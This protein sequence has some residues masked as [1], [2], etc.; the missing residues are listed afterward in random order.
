MKK[1]FSLALA[2]MFF[3]FL[4]ACQQEELTLNAQ[5]DFI[6]FEDTNALC[7]VTDNGHELAIPVGASK[8]YSNDR[9]FSVEIVNANSNAIEGVHYELL[10]PSFKIKAGETKG[11]VRIKGNYEEIDKMDSLGVHLRIVTLGESQLNEYLPESHDIKVRL[12]KYCMPTETNFNGY[13]VVSSMFLYEYNGKE[14]QRLIES[15]FDLETRTIR[16]KNI[17]SDPDIYRDN[18]DLVVRLSEDEMM[19]TLEID[20]DQIIYSVRSLLSQNYG[21]GWVRAGQNANIQPIY[22]ACHNMMMFAHDTYVTGQGY[23]GS[24]QATVQWISDAEAE[25]I[26]LHGF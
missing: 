22:N 14:H 1:Y 21:D 8:V 3:A 9:V 12:M 25:Y 6:G 19:P 15:E 18:Y 24:F 17:Y 4:G 7:L 11:E 2:G 10:T 23:I 5:K 16:L 26:K 13:C 20:G